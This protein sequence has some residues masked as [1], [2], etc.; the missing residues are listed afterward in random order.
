MEFKMGQATRDAYGVALAELGKEMKDVVVLDA[1]LSKSTKTV[2]FA[3][4]YPKR[5][6]NVGIAEANMVGMAVGLASCGKIPFVSSFA[7]F[8][9]CKAFDQ[10]RMGVAYSKS[11]VKIVAS[12]GG[13]SLGEDGASQMSVED[14]G[15]AALLPGVAVLCPSDEVSAKKLV[16]AMAKWNGPAYMRVGRP[17]VPIVHDPKAEFAIGGSAVLRDGKD[18]TVVAC[19]LMVGPALAAAELLKEES[20]LDIR[21]IDAYSLVPLDRK[22]IEKACCETKAMVV[23]DEHL[24]H[25]GLG[26]QVAAAV[27][28]L[29]PVPMGFVGLDSYAESGKTEDL[30]AKYGLTARKVAEKVLQVVARKSSGPQT[31][32]CP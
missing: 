4:K 19:G 18:A 27:G 7:S 24:A 6:F 11:N 26:A 5:F 30:L 9:M 2:E 3:K 21:V 31:C 22:T 1:D 29:C 16:K 12:H 20:K 15:L 10:L 13:I 17:K 32:C 25:M 28:E 8:L 14:L 23:A